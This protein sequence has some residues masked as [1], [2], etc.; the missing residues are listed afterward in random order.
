MN[1]LI[2]LSIKNPTA[3]IAL[4]LLTIIFG[5]VALREIP[6]QM[7]PDIDKPRLQVRVAWKGASPKDVEREII[8]RIERSVSSLS[9]VKKIESDSRYGSGRV[10]LT[11]AVGF[12]L[13]TALIKLLNKIASLDGLPDEASR[14]VVR[15]SN[16]EDSPI[17]RL[18]LIKTE[19]NK[20]Q[21]LS[22]LGD[23]V[24]SEIV[25]KLSRLE[26]VSEITYRGG[27]KKELRVSVDIKK[28][29]YFGISINELINILKSS[30]SQITAGELVEGKR[31]YTLRS[32][33]I[34]YTSESAKK[35]VIKSEKT[36]NGS[37]V[38]VKLGDV[39]D[40]YV[41]HKKPTSFRRINGQNAITFAVLRE[42]N[43]NVVK[44]MKGLSK[45]INLINKSFL[46][47]LDLNLITVYDETIYINNAISL[48]KQNIIIGAIFA[49]CVL[50]IFLRNI[51]PTLII[52]FAIPISVIGTFVAIA[53]LGL[54]INVISLAGLAFAVGM[55][56]DAS[57]VSQENIYRLHQKGLNSNVAALN[58]ANQVWAPILGSALT[59]VVVFIPILL[60]ELPIGQLFRDI[61]IAICVSVLISVLISVTLI[62]SM[63]AISLNNNNKNNKLFTIPLIDG[64]AKGFSNTVI[65][66]V[67][68]STYSLKRG[69]SV[70][71]GI[72]L[73]SILIVIYFIPS[74]DYL[75]DGNRNFVFA[76]IIVPPGYNKEATLDIAKAMENAARPLWE[77]GEKDDE[78]K[79]K[80][81][82]FFFVA[83]SG[84]A[85]AGAATENPDRVRE[86]LPVLTKPIRSQPG[87]KA[88]AQQ[89]SLFGRSVGGSRVIK[90]NVTG[91]S[92]SQINPVAKTMIRSIRSKFSPK[93]GHQVRAVPAL[94]NGSPQ[95]LIKPDNAKLSDY[96][97][98]AKEF[99]TALDV[100]NDGLRISEIPYEGNLID[101]TL[102][103]NKSNLNKIDD[104]KDFPIITKSGEI[105]LLSQLADIE[106]VG[107]PNQIKRLSGKRVLSIQLRPHERI[108]L[109]NA[110]STLEKDI[111]GP[112]RKGLSKDISIELSGAAS[113]LDR[114]WFSMKQNVLIALF[115][116][117]ILLTILM[118]S[119]LLPLIVMIVVPV[120]AAGGI[121]SLGIL[122]NFINQ[123]LDMLTMLG[124][125]I[126]SGVVVNNSILMVEQTLWH[127]KIDK[128][129]IKKSVMEATK[130]RIRPIFMSTLTSLFGLTPLVVFPGAG[131][132]L[133]RGIGTLVF[134]GL[135]MST[136]LTLF[137]IPPLLMFVLKIK[138][139]SFVKSK[140]ETN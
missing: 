125:I 19:K 88:F 67:N 68:W 86:I 119:F 91:T 106:I 135:A 76:R 12:D 11:Y 22:K 81:S 121:I 38:F 72:I 124:F 83:Y 4:I 103:S 123:P 53:S 92:L 133:Y 90:I 128:M 109:E 54:S 110:I 17:A 37:L 118:K 21:E 52:M 23:L 138:E 108:S 77:K 85:F 1:N 5:I 7:T 9:G 80:I 41:S 82:R 105:I 63:A 74:L 102:S 89:A 20:K 15:T 30:S 58:G 10:T 35:I 114:T 73:L 101:M 34:S 112:I 18:V 96:G 16:S 36:I 2:K 131:S 27:T 56:V 117:F 87:A 126:L 71:A 51:R 137:M 79:P 45:E 43:S 8:T 120:A 55:V 139:L 33:S 129:T 48:V 50:I 44:T 127:N 42:P 136:I 3:V 116:I 84:G 78:A 98:T 26:G 75:P 97:I 46:N 140:T 32:E 6:I 134:G 31:T 132:E 70:V 40:V 65:K 25:E 47:P 13:D 59:T 61:G 115:V 24:E 111:I 93:Y 104:I 62:P 122:N 69:L 39:A 100:Y 95:I 94:S 107:M 14:P 130:N 28:L 57:I 60:L 66:Y 29:S 113:E 49:I 64:V 99:S